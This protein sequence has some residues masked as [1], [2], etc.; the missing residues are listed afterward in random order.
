MALAFRS[1]DKENTIREEFISFLA[2][3]YGLSGQS[4][5]SNYIEQE[6]LGSLGKDISECRGQGYNGVGAVAGKNQRLSAHALGVNPKAPDT[7]CSCHRL[8]LAVVRT[9][10][11]ETCLKRDD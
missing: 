5:Y 8:N 9:T 7:Y 6:L 11:N 1:V 10:N 2:C 4:L 3:S